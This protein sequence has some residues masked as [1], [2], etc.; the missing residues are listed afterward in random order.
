MEDPII[1]AKL[2]VPPPGGLRRSRLDA[3]LNRS[4]QV[5][6]TVVVAPPG[7][8]KTTQLAMFARA[9]ASAGRSVAWYQAGRAEGGSGRLLRYLEAALR[10]I[11]PSLPGGW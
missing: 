6:L 4:W 2:R 1:P 9:Q 7:S 11:H 5:P 10:Q 8:G 3:L